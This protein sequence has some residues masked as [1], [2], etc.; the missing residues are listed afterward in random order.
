[1]DDASAKARQHVVQALVGL[2]L[3][4][5]FL[6]GLHTVADFDTGWQMATGRYV[7]EHRLIPDTDVF[8]FTAHG[9]EWI[10]PPLPG[11]ILYALYSLAGFSALSW[12]SAFACCATIALLLRRDSAMIATLAIMAV[13]VIVFRTTPRAELFSTALFAAFVAIL[14]RQ[15]QGERVWLWLLPLLMAAWVNL[16]Q[17]FVTGLAMMGA[18]VMLELSEM[19]FAGRR[20]PAVLRLRR[21]VPWLM[22]TA[23]ATLVNPWGPRIY[24]AI[25]RLMQGVQDLGGLVTEWRKSYISPTA[26]LQDVLNWRNPDSGYWWL[27]GAVIAAIILTLWRKQMGV[28]GL[29]AGATYFSLAH[30]RYQGLF[31]CL[32]VMVGGSVLSSLALP[33]WSGLKETAFGRGR[34]GS[35]GTG[36]LLL[37]GGMVLLVGVRSADLISN[38]YYLSSGQLTLFGP[39]ASWW[40][41]ERASAFLLREHL[42]E[43]VFNDYDLGGYLT[44][45]IGPEYPDYVDGRAYPFGAAMLFH[46]DSLM[47]Q[48][49]DSA[50]WQQEAD[51]Y[52]INTIM[53]SVARYAGLGNF[54]LPQFCQSQLWRPV[55]LD[56]VAA[57]FVRNVPENAELI[58]RLQ[59]NCSTVPIHPAATVGAG[60]QES[61]ERYNAFANAGSLLYMLGRSAEALKDLQSAEAIFP[62]DSNLHLTMGE[63][64]QANNLFGQAEEEFRTSV[65]LRPTDIAWYVLGRMYVAEHRFDDAAQAFSHAAEL[66]YQPSDRYLTLAEDY[67]LMQR[68]EDAL[69][70]FAHAVRL[71][72]YESNSPEGAAFYSRIAAGRA[73]ACVIQSM[74]GV[75]R[76]VEFQKQALQLTPLDPLR[77]TQLADLYR[78]QGR[79]DLSQQASRRARELSSK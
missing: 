31:A 28:A 3:A 15:F 22:G 9:K 66:S 62:G 71:S 77:W 59:I 8:S 21:S 32:A 30:L 69:K 78:L 44:W 35:V 27:V 49:P 74:E 38:R 16:H 50:D 25:F 72:P 24:P 47:Q 46:H 14:W 63:L 37:L 67:I 7:F 70:E 23:I 2:A 73:R 26:T 57:I 42:P 17:G 48:T 79:A 1:M 53:V 58:N 20:N 29:L 6:A 64:Y 56:E 54:R 36:R 51:R 40:F 55:Y 4:Y 75:D 52:H 43:N 18:Y 39:G 12:L 65:R 34:L 68:P 19:P 61:G 45:R 60:W 5:A 13:P 10:Y 76:A 33:A 41:P 11:L